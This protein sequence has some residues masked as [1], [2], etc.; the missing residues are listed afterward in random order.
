MTVYYKYQFKLLRGRWLFWRVPRPKNSYEQYIDERR[1][2][3]EYQKHP[4]FG[5][6]V[7]P[8]LPVYLKY[9]IKN[10]RTK[11]RN[12]RPGIWFYYS[13]YPMGLFSK[14]Y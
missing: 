8:T 2:R 1:R 3:E 11:I 14:I 12:S 9:Y 7:M 4:T 6:P 10:Y 5:G 13:I